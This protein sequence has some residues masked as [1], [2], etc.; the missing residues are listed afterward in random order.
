VLKV[1][2]ACQACTLV[3]ADCVPSPIAAKIGNVSL[4]NSQVARG[5]AYSVGSPAQNFTFLP[6]W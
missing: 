2:L 3:F 5:I 4:S 6:Q 1:F